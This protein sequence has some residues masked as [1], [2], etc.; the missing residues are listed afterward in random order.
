MSVSYSRNWVFP[1]WVAVSCWLLAGWGMLPGQ[2]TL[3]V[4]DRQGEPL[5]GATVIRLPNLPVG[6]ADEDGA[7]YLPEVAAN[8][9]F[10]V[11]YIGFTPVDL[12]G[13]FLTGNAFD[14]TL[15][16]AIS[17][18]GMATIVGRRDELA[19]EL[20]YQIETVSGGAGSQ[21]QSL[22]TAD[23]LAKLSGVY[24]QKSQLGGGSPV[25]RGFEAN[26]VLL[27]VDGVRLNNAIYRNGHLQNAI[28]VDPNALDRIELIYGAG[29]LAYGSDAIGGVV[30][31]RTLQP[32]F[33]SQNGSKLSG[34]QT[35]NWSSAARA[36]NVAGRINFGAE[37]WASLT[38]YSL[39]H[40]GDLRAGANRPDRF[41]E[42]G[43]R[44]SYVDLTRGPAQV[45]TNETPNVQKGSGYTQYNFLQKLRYR[46]REKLELSANLQF[47]TTSEV[48][49][50]DALIERRNGELR[51]ARWDYGP[52]T[53]LLGSLR[54][55]DRR[56]TKF[57]DLATYLLSY[58][59]I[60]EDRIRRRLGDERD[61]LSLVDVS[62][63]NAQLDYALNVGDGQN[64]RYG[65]DARRDWVSAS[66]TEATR[67]PSQ[68]SSLAAAGT[69]L[70]L[71]QNIGR[72]KLRGGVRYSYQRLEATFG[73][74][75][76]VEWPESY[77]AGLENKTGSLT[78]AF[79]ARYRLKS[80]NWR[81]LFAQGFRAPNIDDFAKFRERN[82]RIQVPNPALEAER[83]NTLEA[84]YTHESRLRLTA[85]GYVTFLRN[86]IIRRDGSLPD[87]R[88]QFVSG[89]DTLG[90]QANVN[91]DRAVVYGGDI[92]A[93]LTLGK[94]WEAGTEL[95]WLRGRRRQLAPDGRE[96]T[97]PQDH[98]PPA[99]G[100]GRL[101]YRSGPWDA[102][103]QIDF[104]LA[105]PLGDYSVNTISGSFDDGYSFDRTGTSDNLELTPNEEGSYGWWTLDCYA[106]RQLGGRAAVRLK[107]ENL[108]DLHYRT[109]ASGISAP[110]IDVGV[111]LS[112]SW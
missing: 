59:F 27:V 107:V 6:L 82:G 112:V 70:D 86:A 83:S 55:S 74:D 50:Y 68:G 26:R 69:Y 10:R 79:G 39:N 87:G 99:Y 44:E 103:I 19:R 38:Q 67:Y 12:P 56:K 62:V 20:P 104:Q 71:S 1:R 72:W 23:M 66:A 58:Q 106:S 52:Q 108:L 42:F 3:T 31:F 14:I 77:L 73:A 8:D 54:L 45:V 100:R 15:D 97:L 60:E 98:I 96:L 90:V 94:D 30:H 18:V 28:T 81:L 25:V 24:V 33:R 43:K 11:S 85:T 5:V 64:L 29:A 75:D 91:A 22:T 111:G 49:R 51:W 46:P 4:A 89:G 37:R 48:P 88:T 9:T 53:R 101:S 2:V 110:G 17:M 7:V 13:T 47:S 65:F 105:K 41:S 92:V 84:A 16:P 80:G 35:L 57:Y 36:V 102:R 61:E 109:F 93:A 76:P 32:Q 95:H 78:V 34:Q 63:M 40:F 21:V